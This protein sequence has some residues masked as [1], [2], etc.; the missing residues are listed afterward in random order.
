M[1]L[2]EDGGVKLKLT[3]IAYGSCRDFCKMQLLKYP[4]TMTLFAK[5]KVN[6][7]VG[8]IYCLSALS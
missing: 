6:C 1:L 4:S 3:A 2:A 5:E 7:H 8:F